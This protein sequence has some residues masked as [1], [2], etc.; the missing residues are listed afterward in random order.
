MAGPGC[1]RPQVCWLGRDR[2][3]NWRQ[4][5]KSRAKLFCIKNGGN[6]ER[7]EELG[8]DAGQIWSL[9]IEG[10]VKDGEPPTGGN[11]N[12]KKPGASPPVVCKTSTVYLCFMRW[13]WV[14][15]GVLLMV[16]RA[17]RD[18]VVQRSAGKP[19]SLA[20]LSFKMLSAPPT[21]L[22]DWGWWE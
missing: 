9:W 6:L 8:L 1:Q 18:T 20:S 10:Q 14:L 22:N 13:F 2:C 17:R 16:M 7:P 11:P 5:S 4:G 12:R 3:R 21:F 15:E 19:E